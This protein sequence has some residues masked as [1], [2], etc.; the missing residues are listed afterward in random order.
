MVILYTTTM[1][2]CDTDSVAD[3]TSTQ[4]A[5]DKNTMLSFVLCCEH[6]TCLLLSASERTARNAGIDSNSIV[7]FIMQIRIITQRNTTPL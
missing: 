3:E 2:Y 5:C 1:I 4:H 6:V 7:A